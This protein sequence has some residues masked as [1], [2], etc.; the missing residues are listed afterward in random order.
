MTLE[1]NLFFGCI[2]CRNRDQVCFPGQQIY[3]S[4]RSIQFL[5]AKPEFPRQQGHACEADSKWNTEPVSW[6]FEGIFGCVYLQLK[7]SLASGTT[8]RS[9][10]HKERQREE[11]IHCMAAQSKSLHWP[12]YEEVNCDHLTF[13]RLTLEVSCSRLASPHVAIH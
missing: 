4:Y 5:C 3:K 6:G 10:E 12:D 9:I 7:C 11:W 13:S 8:S 2:N 1:L